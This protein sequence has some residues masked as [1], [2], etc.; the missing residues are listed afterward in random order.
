MPSQTWSGEQ[1]DLPLGNSSASWCTDACSKLI[2]RNRAVLLA[3][4]GCACDRATLPCALIEHRLDGANHALIQLKHQ[5]QTGEPHSVVAKTVSKME[6]LL[7]VGGA[8]GP[9]DEFIDD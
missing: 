3:R 5:L 4:G 7:A 8:A 9:G 6:G 2:C 1:N